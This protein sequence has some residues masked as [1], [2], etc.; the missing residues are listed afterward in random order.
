MN[1]NTIQ[2]CSLEDQQISAGGVLF[3]KS[4]TELNICVLVK[5]GGRILTLPH[6]RVNEGESPEETARREVLEETGHLGEVHGKIDEIV[7]DFFWS[8]NKTQYH[9]TVTFFLMSLV[10]ENAQT[11]DDEADEVIWIP[12]DQIQRR[13]SYRNEREI[14]RKARHLF[15]HGKG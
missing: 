4:S 12:L 6:G 1:R 5:K 8:E 2:D 13:L 15:P 9:K 7:Y 14:V 3:R 10:Q 11:R